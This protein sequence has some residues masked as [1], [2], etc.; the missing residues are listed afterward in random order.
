M[1]EA[2]TRKIIKER[3][4]GLCEKCGQQRGTEAHHRKNRSQGGTWEPTNILLLCHG[5]HAWITTHP[6]LAT[7]AGWAV[8]RNCEPHLVPVKIAGQWTLLNTDN[9][10]SFPFLEIDPGH[11]AVNPGRP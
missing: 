3:S 9:T 6:A 7:D 10:V 11:E 8:S 5:C 1:G 4:N 2:A